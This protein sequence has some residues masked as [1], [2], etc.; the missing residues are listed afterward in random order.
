MVAT[1]IDDPV[2]LRDSALYLVTLLGRPQ[3]VV[4]R[5]PDDELEFRVECSPGELDIVETFGHVTG[6]QQPIVGVVA[7]GRERFAVCTMIQ[8]EIAEGPKLHRW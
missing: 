6:Y 4:A 8:V 1:Q 3:L 2:I 7:K 5:R